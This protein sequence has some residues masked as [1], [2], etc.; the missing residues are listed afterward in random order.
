MGVFAEMGRDVALIGKRPAITAGL[1]VDGF[2]VW[3]C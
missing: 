3:Q 1:L 2:G